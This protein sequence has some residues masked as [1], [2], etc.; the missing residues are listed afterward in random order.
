MSWTVVRGIY[1]KGVVEPLERAPQ[2]EGVEVL[3]LFPAQSPAASQGTWQRI[4][5]DLAREMPELLDMTV[6]D[7]R[8]EFTRL[9]RKVTEQMPY[10]SVEEFERAMR[11]DEYDLTGH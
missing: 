6:D 3:V 2:R 8:E 10:Q 9:S 1:K 4:K 11:G 7:K 5:H